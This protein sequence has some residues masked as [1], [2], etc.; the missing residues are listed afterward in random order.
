MEE[1]RSS[2]RACSSDMIQFNTLLIT[3]L[4]VYVFRSLFQLTLSLANISHLRRHGNNVPRVFQ[5]RVDEEKFSR[6]AAYT[7][8]S[9]RFGIGTRLFDQGLLL[10]IVLS[11]FLPWLVR[12]IDSWPLGF[13]GSGLVFFAL[14][15]LIGH[16][17]DIPFDLYSTFVIEE[18]HGFNTRTVRLWFSDWAKDLTISFILAGIV[19]CLLLVLISFFR[20]IWWLLAWMAISVF[21][22]LMMW[23]YP[24]VIAPLF[25]KFEPITDRELE[26]KIR[27]L[28]EKAGLAVRGVFQMDA[29]RR[30]RHTNAY[31]TGIGRTKRIVLFDTLLGSHPE[32]E[33]M[34]VLAHEAGH[35]MKKHTIKQLALLEILSLVGLF[36]LAR[37]LDWPVLYRTF[38]LQEDTLYVGLF[39]VPVVLGPLGYFLRPIG[40]A[41]S[42][43]YEREADD[44]AVRLMG[45]AGPMKEALIRLSS[46][47]LANLVPHPAFSWFNY[48][49]PPPV[50]RIERLEHLET[51]A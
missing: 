31:F 33:I 11:G 41:L 47:N 28:M 44:V 7:L 45:R 13:I 30:S 46:D 14:L 26:I 32:V 22:L 6:M 4:A 15:A 34:A 36:I 42:R 9:T 1:S 12:V 37:L 16:L 23:L 25:N 35:W 49:H 40:S 18:R 39:L 19:L 17:V 21:E 20:E 50:E 3:F 38:G 29:G 8:D 10:V 51:A 27:G 2:R 24:V 5:G 43:K 48:S